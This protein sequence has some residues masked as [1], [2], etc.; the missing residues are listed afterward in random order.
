G[1]LNLLSLIRASGADGS[2]VSAGGGAGGSVLIDVDN[3]F[4]AGR[5]EVKGG[6]GFGLSGGGGGGGRVAIYTS[7]APVG[8]QVV[9][10]GGPSTVGAAGGV[11][12]VIK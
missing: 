10:D 2:G 12:T 6:A 7:G 1:T 8:F 11:G 9:A 4:G 5:V 3:G